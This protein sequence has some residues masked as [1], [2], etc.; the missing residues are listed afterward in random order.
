M[1]FLIFGLVIYCFFN[2][3][4]GSWILIAI[5]AL[6]E[7]WILLANQTKIKVKNKNN[8]YTQKE[9]ELIEKYRL[10]FQ[11]PFFCRSLSRVF[12]ATQLSAFILVPLFLINSLIP[13]AIIIGINYFIASQFAVILNPQFFLHDNIDK[14]RVKDPKLIARYTENMLAIDSALKKMYQSRI[15]KTL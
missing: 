11:Y 5:V 6:F 12:S 13:Q 14:R 3:N 2:P 8:K 9:V 15:N 7:A 4:V 1:Q 10:F